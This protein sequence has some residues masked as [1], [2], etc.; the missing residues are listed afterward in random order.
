MP[1]SDLPNIVMVVLDTA[2]W[3]RFGCYGYERPTTPAV[4]ALAE[5]GLRVDT[6]IANAPWTLPAHGSLF[7]GLYP[8]EHGSQWQTGPRLRDGVQLTMAEWLGGIGYETVCA[9][10]NGLISKRTGLARGFER[11]AFRLDLERGP[12]R[13]ARQ[14][15]R[16]LFGGDSGGRIMNQW[17]RSELRDV[18]KPMFLF[19]NYLECHWAYAPPLEFVKRVGGPRY[20]YLEGLN[21]R[22]T[23]AAKTG[24]WE[25]IARARQ[26]DLEVYST[27]YDGELANA[28]DHVRE[29]EEILTSTGHMRPDGSTVFIVTSDHGEHLGERGLADHHADL[30]DLL[31]RVPF[32]AWGPGIVPSGVRGGISELVDVLPSLARLIDKELPLPYLDGRRTDVLTSVEN[33]DENRYAVA[34]WRSWTPKERDRLHRRNPAYD[35]TGLARDLVCARDGRF[36]LVRSGDRGETLFDLE[37]DPG[38]TTDAAPLHPEAAARL[39]NELDS[40]IEQWRPWE[41]TGAAGTTEE[42]RKEIEQRLSELGYI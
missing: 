28:D 25:A 33:A 18:K 42:E 38:E 23:F 4:D 19:V 7:T 37:S 27:Y 17:L 36:K 11:Y 1:R 29:L 21:Y 41:E 12:K 2:R 5:E 30:D 16:L 15:R 10:S 26:R 8:S 24:P 31:L 20:S 22:R 34:E 40:R 39:R 35:F 13:V 6:M 32:V 3:D 9:T 14:T